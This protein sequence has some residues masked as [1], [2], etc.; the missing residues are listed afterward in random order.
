MRLVEAALVYVD[1]RIQRNIR[2]SNVKVSNIGR[3]EV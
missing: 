3:K 1:R 2:F